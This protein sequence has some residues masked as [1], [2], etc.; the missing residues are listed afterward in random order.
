VSRHAVT[1][2]AHH[3]DQTVEMSSFEAL[4]AA[5]CLV[6]SNSRAPATGMIMSNACP[7]GC[8]S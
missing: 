7:N 2:L 5:R 6:V 8:C 3:V 4:L 1:V